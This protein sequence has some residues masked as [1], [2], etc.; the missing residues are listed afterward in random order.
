[1]RTLLE[2]IATAAARGCPEL[3]EH[4]AFY[5][6]ACRVKDVHKACKHRRLTT[7]TAKIALLR[8]IC[9]WQELHKLVQAEIAWLWCFVLGLDKSL[10]LLDTF[11]IERQ[12]HRGKG[13]A[14]AV[15]NTRTFSAYVLMRVLGSRIT[16]LHANFGVLTPC[17]LGRKIRTVCDGVG[18]YVAD[19]R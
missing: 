13:H 10:W 12:R 16:A 17:M 9:E 14:E 5:A 19:S 2:A 8:L 11:V 4:R 18:A 1:M 3:L 7:A 6:A 15:Q